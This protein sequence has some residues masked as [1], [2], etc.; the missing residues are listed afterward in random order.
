MDTIKFDRK[1]SLLVAHAGHGFEMEN[2]IPGFITAAN[3]NYYAI[4]TDLHITKDKK[5][6]I[7]HDRN[8]KRISG[9]DMVVKESTLAELQAIPLYDKEEGKFRS[10][11]RVPE[12]SEYIN[13]CKRFDKKIVLELKA[14]FEEEDAKRLIEL[15]EE[16]EY[17]SETIFISFWWD[18]LVN[19][20]K[21]LPAQEVQFLTGENF[22]FT[23]EFIE[24]IAK[25]KFDVDIHMWTASKEN[26][27]K[28][29]SKG[30]KVNV[31]TVDDKEDGERIAS[32]GA[33]FITSNWLE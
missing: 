19:I 32:Y 10:D 12:L 6:V 25:N 21:F 9:V 18:N 29:H 15:F 23:E 26:I 20:R 17:L 31:W 5:F 3:R 30:I 2:T 33:D 16:C 22:E 14:K 13:I 24:K 27:E 11:L 7:L 8:M 28:F 4:E 1:N